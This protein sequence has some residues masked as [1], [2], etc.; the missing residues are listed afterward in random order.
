M[1][2]AQLSQATIIMQPSSY[3]RQDPPSEA[4]RWAA[5]ISS[6][7]SFL[8]AASNPHVQIMLSRCATSQVE[9]W[10]V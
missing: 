8:S 4:R 2:G 9:K 5:A 7:K 6:G 3:V 10:R 1:L